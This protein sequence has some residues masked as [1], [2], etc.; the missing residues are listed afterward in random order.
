MIE[1]QNY[2]NGSIALITRKS[3]NT[4]CSNAII[5]FMPSSND[6]ISQFLLLAISNNNF[7]KK[8]EYAATVIG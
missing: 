5:S 4:I 6:V 1:K 2:F 3:N 8:R 7:L